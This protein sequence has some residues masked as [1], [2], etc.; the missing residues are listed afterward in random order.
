MHACTNK[1]THT[2]TRSQALSFAPASFI[3]DSHF[4]G[5]RYILY[6]YYV[7]HRAITHILYERSARTTC[8]FL[9]CRASTGTGTAISIQAAIP[10]AMICVLKRA[11]NISHFFCCSLPLMCTHCHFVDLLLLLSCYFLLASLDFKFI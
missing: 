9:C 7:M 3:E 6:T 5:S 8:H 4:C 1:R 10:K 2:L 11:Y